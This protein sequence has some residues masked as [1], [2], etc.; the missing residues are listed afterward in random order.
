MGIDRIRAKG[1]RRGVDGFYKIIN[2]FWTDY[3]EL[4]IFCKSLKSSFK[5]NGQK[6]RMV[7]IPS[8]SVSKKL[9]FKFH[10]SGSTHGLCVSRDLLKQD[11]FVIFYFSI[12]ISYFF[13]F[14]TGPCHRVWTLGS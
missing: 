13:S 6:K 9:R 3:L 5:L 4:K 8:N 11:L 7:R 12:R 2:K 14:K 1:K 10:I